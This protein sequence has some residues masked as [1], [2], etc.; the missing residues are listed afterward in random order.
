MSTKTDSYVFH[1]ER[2]Y[3]FLREIVIYFQFPEFE[4]SSV[5]RP[6]VAV[7]VVVGVVHGRQPRVAPL[8]VGGSPVTFEVVT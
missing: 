7:K 8:R 1:P 4:E 2:S 5:F 6:E 3:E